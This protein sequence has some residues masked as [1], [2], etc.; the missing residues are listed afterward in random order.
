[1]MDA[2]RIES[3]LGR[4]PKG[5]PLLQEFY[6]DPEIFECDSTAGRDPSLAG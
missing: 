2:H 6:S 1:M 4:Q 5:S 3:L